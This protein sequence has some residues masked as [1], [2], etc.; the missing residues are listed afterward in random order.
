MHKEL[1]SAQD[2]YSWLV[3][4]AWCHE[5]HSV[6]QQRS[7]SPFL[8]M[9]W[10]SIG[11]RLNVLIEGF[12]KVFWALLYKYFTLFPPHICPPVTSTPPTQWYFAAY[13]T[14]NTDTDQTV[15][16]K[17]PRA[18]KMPTLS[19]LAVHIYC[20]DDSKIQFSRFAGDHRDGVMVI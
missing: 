16:R 14:T 15:F 17:I 19:L 1:S 3:D 2:Q 20:D 10:R 6:N 12:I 11:L 9:T 4:V 13:G 18:V 5:K 7:N 8:W